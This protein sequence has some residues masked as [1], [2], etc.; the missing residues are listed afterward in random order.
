MKTYPEHIQKWHTEIIQ[1]LERQYPNQFDMEAY[2]VLS[3]RHKSLIIPSD[4][5]TTLCNVAQPN[6]WTAFVTIIPHL[7]PNS[8]E[9]LKFAKKLTNTP[10]IKNNRFLKNIDSAV[11]DYELFCNSVF[12]SLDNKDMQLVKDFIKQISPICKEGNVLEKYII[13]VILSCIQPQGTSVEANALIIETCVNLFATCPT[14]FGKSNAF[15]QDHLISARNGKF[16]MEAFLLCLKNII[17]K[18]KKPAVDFSQVDFSIDNDFNKYFLWL[19]TTLFKTY[20]N[21]QKYI[22]FFIRYFCE[23]LSTKIEFLL[24]LALFCGGKSPEISIICLNVLINLLEHALAREIQ[25][26][27]LLSTQEGVLA[28]YLL[29]LLANTS[30]GIK[31]NVFKIINIFSQTIQVER[32]KLLFRELL[33]QEE[34]IISDST[35]LSLII[36]NFVTSATIK[37]K[38]VLAEVNILKSELLKYSCSS[39]SPLYLKNN[40]LAILSQ[41]NSVEIFEDT[42]LDC[43]TLLQTDAKSFSEVKSSIIIHNIQRYQENISNAISLQSNVW[44]LLVILLKTDNISITVDDKIS[45]PAVL[46]LRQLDKNVFGSFNE[47]V[48]AKVLDL[49]IETTTVSKNS[50]VLPEARRLIK[51]V[52]LDSQLILPHF[53]AMRDVQS[54]RLDPNKLKRR[55]SVVPTIDILDTLAWRKGVT[56]LE[57][58]QE[59]KKLR[60]TELLLPVLFD[61]LKKCLDFDE[62]TAVEYPKQLILSSIL[63]LGAK[64]EQKFL[65][66]TVFNIELIVQCIR[67]SQNPQTHYCALLVLSFAAGLFPSQV[68]HHTMTIFTFM[69]SSL[70]R[71]EDAYSFQIIGKTINTIVPILIQNSTSD[72]IANVLRVFVDVLVDVPEHRRLSIYKQLIDKIGVNDHLH[73][74]LLLIFESHVNHSDRNKNEDLKRLEIAAAICREFPPKS[75][76][77]SCVQLIKYLKDLPDEIDKNNWSSLYGILY[78]NPKQ[79]R[80]FKYTLILFLIRLLTSKEFI[81]QIAVMPND[82]LLEL[83]ELYKN[84]IVNI[85]T[86]I[87]RVS[88][89]AEKTSKA[90]QGKYWKV[91]LHLSYD[92]LDSVNAL[93]TPQMFLLV[94]KGLMVHSFLT[95]RR[96]S[97]ELLNTK[98]QNDSTFFLERPHNEIYSLVPPLINSIKMIEDTDLETEEEILIQTALLSLKLLVKFL[99]QDYSSQLSEILDFLTNLIKSGKAQ[100]NVLASLIL[101]LAE[102]CSSLRA[103]ALS[104]MPR[105]M[106]ALIKTLKHQK[107]NDTSSLLLLSCLTAIQKILENLSLFLSPY[108]EKLVFELSILS[109]KWPQETEDEKLQPIINKLLLIRQQMGKLIPSRVLIPVLGQTYTRLLE[110][111]IFDSIGFIMEVLEENLQNLNGNEINSNLSELTTFFLNALQ[112]RTEQRATFK[113]TNIVEAKIVKALTKLILKLSESSFKPLYYKLFDWAIRSE[114][115]SERIITFY[116]LSSSIAES[117]KSIFVLFAGHFINNAAQILDSC[118]TIKNDTLYFDEQEKNELLLGHVLKTLHTVFTYDNSKFISKDR[119]EILMQPLVDQLE[120]TLD[121]VEEL[122]RRNDSVITPCIVQFAVA[123]ADDS[124]WKQLNYQIL[125]KMKHNVPNIRLIALYCMNEMVRKVGVDYLPLLPESIPV[126]AE[127]LEDED[128][129][130]EKACRKAVQEMEKVLGEPIEKYFKM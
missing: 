51:I 92:I 100:N 61:I 77:K 32:Y 52:E 6:D 75:V 108:L 79:F 18:T 125:L 11:A 124:L 26:L 1:T 126:L 9:Q 102:L 42:A 53:I 120:N 45:C 93:L 66:E 17:L 21:H 107:N 115:R 49:V 122:E 27:S 123:T 103:H 95:V 57:F 65:T 55:I 127:L 78:K 110:K 86:Y 101:C 24:N 60:N 54:P 62:Q 23:G 73:I 19:A 36:Y 46:I 128:E 8:D 72:K 28:V 83:E 41:M 85:L 105:Y 112:F 58:I 12:D 67:A 68:L 43:I 44:N 59:K 34:E 3:L 16:H 90:A 96:R 4:Q 114:V 109:K 118:N 82:S 91:I 29:A 38:K 76:L 97:L 10:F 40:I 81:N 20:S 33:N 104:S 5:I 56:A 15:F 80:H 129:T 74:F 39:N 35:Q 47:D 71:H 48:A 2:K 111:K 69:G 31:E 117:L 88:K 25:D 121:G 116:A 106:P 30:R 84:V 13:T 99:I 14:K 64:I 119:F 22:L 63:Y 89:V 70:L 37:G 50:D 94:M 7:L 87:Q 113:Q 130:V 98:L